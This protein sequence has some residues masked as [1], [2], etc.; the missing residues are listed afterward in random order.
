M[1]S[2]AF[3]QIDLFCLYLIFLIK[4]G[5]FFFIF[6]VGNIS[7]IV[8]VHPKRIWFDVVFFGLSSSFYCLIDS[9]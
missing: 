5:I 9:C 2:A 1:P 4:S 8:P 6:S 3:I 7:P